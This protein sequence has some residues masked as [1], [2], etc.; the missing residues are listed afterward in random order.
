MCIITDM[1]VEHI[2]LF[3]NYNCK[4]F[5]P[6]IEHVLI[7]FILF[8]INW[9]LYLFTF[10]CYPFSWFPLWKSPTTTHL[11]ASMRV[12]P[13]PTTDSH[14]ALAFLYPGTSSLHSI[15][16]LPS[17]GCQIRPFKFIHSFPNLYIGVPVL[18]QMVVF[19]SPHHY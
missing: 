7:L 14:I 3:T 8:Y 17:N 9:I 12:F 1:N 2:S 19:E 5:P 10:Q 13:Y 6:S 18:S 11:P 16:G 15:K 4:A